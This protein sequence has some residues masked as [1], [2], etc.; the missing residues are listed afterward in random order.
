MTKTPTTLIEAIRYFADQD[1]CLD[2]VARLRW[3]DGKAT[4]PTC[5]SQDVGFIKTRRLWKCK[6]KHP[7]RQFSVKVGTVIED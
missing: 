4:C 5:G 6:T 3:P 1:V 2:F 7:R